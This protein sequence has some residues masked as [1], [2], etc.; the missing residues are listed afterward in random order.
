MVGSPIRSI[1]RLIRGIELSGALKFITVHLPM[2]CFCLFL[3][4][5]FFIVMREAGRFCVGAPKLKIKK[6]SVFVCLFVFQLMT[7]KLVLD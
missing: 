5:I 3:F 4:F 2:D 6:L 1:G 7:D